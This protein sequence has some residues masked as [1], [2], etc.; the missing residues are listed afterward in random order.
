MPDPAPDLETLKRRW[1][2]VIGISASSTGSH[3]QTQQSPVYLPEV[4]EENALGEATHAK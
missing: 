4:L 1:L 2:A 3:K